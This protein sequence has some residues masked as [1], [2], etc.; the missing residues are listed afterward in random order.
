MVVPIE[1]LP[2]YGGDWIIWF[3]ERQPKGGDAPSMRAP[4]PF[5][6]FEPADRA[7]SRLH[8]EWRLQVAAVIRQDGKLE[9]ISLVRHGAPAAEQAVIQDLQSW[10]FRPA[11]RAGVPVDVDVVIEIPFILQP[12]VSLRTWP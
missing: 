6:K 8:V 4:V 7:L 9:S 1:N 10:E 11:T 2:D 3:A 5:R 12:E